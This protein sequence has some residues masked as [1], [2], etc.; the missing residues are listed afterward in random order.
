MPDLVAPAGPPVVVA[1]P[2]ALQQMVARLQGVPA[3][4]VDT[5]ANSFY[6]YYERVCLVQLTFD[7]TDYVVDPLALSDLSALGPIFADPAIEKVF[8]A[9]EYDLIGLKRDYSFE[10]ASLFD[11]MVASRIVGWPAIG[12]ASVLEEQFG[13][14]L[15]KRWQRADWGRRPL[16][17]EQ[18][19][20]ARLDTHYLLPL[21]DLL[22]AELRRL[23]REKEAREEFARLARAAP[24]PHEFDPEGFWHVKGARDLSPSDAAVLRELYLYRDEQ[25]RHRN[26]PPFKVFSDTAM[27]RVSQIHPRD[28]AALVRVPGMSEYV[29]RRYGNGILGAVSRGMRARPLPPPRPSNNHRPDEATL[30]RLAALKVW[31]KAQAQERGVDPDVVCSNAALMALARRNPRTEDELAAVSDLGAWKRS[32]YGTAILQVLQILPVPRQRP[33]QRRR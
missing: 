2:E 27:V 3:V 7:G 15:D 13:V 1:T 25:A 20:Y 33:R 29:I 14:Q 32:E 9:A 19:D 30:T 26:R 31:R 16:P 10:F 28:R 6:A 11:T 21:R 4:A 8:H 18:L 24:V 23:G 5:E 22:L 17:L 12:L